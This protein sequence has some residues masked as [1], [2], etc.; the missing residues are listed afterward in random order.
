[1]A[2]AIKDVAREANLSISTISKYMNG[3]TVKEKNRER[4][5]AAIEKLGYHPNEFARGLR[6]ASTRTIGVLLHSLQD[7][8]SADH[9][10]TIEKQLRAEGYSMVL[11]SHEGNLGLAREALEFLISKQ[12][13]GLLLEPLPG[14]EQSLL[15]FR[16]ANKPVVSVDSPIDPNQYDSV[17]SN[18]MIGIYQGVEYLIGKGHRKI[19]MISGGLNETKTLRTSVDRI[20]G[21]TRAMEDYNLPIRREWVIAG[22]FHFQSGYNAMKKL[23]Q[24]SNKPTALIIA[25]YYMC[26]GAMRAIHELKIRIPE[27][28][29]LVT[30]D[31]MALTWIS[32]PTL[33]CIEQPIQE[34]ADEA[35]SLLIRRLQGDTHDFPKSIKLYT[36]FIERESVRENRPIY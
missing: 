7:A 18:S 21:F 32:T 33:T 6:D 19:G 31:N 20:N 26:L 30:M 1:M 2:V 3:G 13:D 36:S 24:C 16:T 28:L 5:E 25:N 14:I 8:S 23:W 10:A 22:D 9:V 34:M 11:I 12:V 17:T 35:V 27:D 29:S 15:P 4:I